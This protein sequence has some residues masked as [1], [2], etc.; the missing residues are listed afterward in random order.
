MNEPMGGREHVPYG[1][2][3]PSVHVCAHKYMDGQ[4]CVCVLASL[5]LGPH[6]SRDV[7]A[8]HFDVPELALTHLA[9]IAIS[10]AYQQALQ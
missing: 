10:K 4:S 8:A 6:C 7:T 2:L 3:C 1:K 9:W 5:Y